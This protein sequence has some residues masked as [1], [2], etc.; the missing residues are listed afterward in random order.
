MIKNKV[1]FCNNLCIYLKFKYSLNHKL[2]QKKKPVI[3]QALL[4]D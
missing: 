2:S 1:N 3:T 4:Y